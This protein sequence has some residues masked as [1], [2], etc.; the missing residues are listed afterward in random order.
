MM[1]GC[2][3]S[4][5]RTF[6]AE[7]YDPKVADNVLTRTHRFPQANGSLLDCKPALCRE[8][9]REENWHDRDAHPDCG[10]RV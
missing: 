6:W 9:W 8:C 7:R 5:V 3:V 2:Y 1:P 10:G 4:P